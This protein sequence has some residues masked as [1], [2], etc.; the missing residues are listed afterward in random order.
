MWRTGCLVL[1]ITLMAYSAG[2]WLTQDFRVWTSEGARRL[3]VAQTPVDAPDVAMLRSDGVEARLPDL[4]RS[5][6]AITI[7]DLV[8]TRCAT[9]CLALGSAFQQMQSELAA[10]ATPAAA[11]IRLVSISFDPAHDTPAVLTAYSRAQ[12]AD[13]KRWQWAVPA[14]STDLDRL[15]RAFAVV[16]IP[17]GLGGYEHNAGLL[18]I[19]RNGRLVRVFDPTETSPALTFA[20]RLAAAGSLS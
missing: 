16:V 4:L 18:V 1:A 20:R 2:S 10:D 15:L 14:R 13:P 9:V 3:S 8:Y 7:V 11:R 17:D 19:D 6:D 5:R 12:R